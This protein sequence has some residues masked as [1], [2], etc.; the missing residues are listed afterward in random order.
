M[1][2]FFPYWVNPWSKDWMRQEG[3]RPHRVMIRQTP[4]V[5][6]ERSDSGDVRQTMF[7]LIVNPEGGD[8][9]LLWLE[10]AADCDGESSRVTTEGSFINADTL[11]L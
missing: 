8:G 11:E 5:T 3:L 4:T 6:G 7:Y 2:N 1:E 10:T 9:F